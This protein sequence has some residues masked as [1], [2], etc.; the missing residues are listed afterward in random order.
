MFGIR[1]IFAMKRLPKARFSSFWSQYQPSVST[2]PEQ[3]SGRG[4]AFGQREQERGEALPALRHAE[5]RGLLDP[6]DRVEAGVGETDD[7]RARGLRLQDEGRKSGEFSGWRTEPTI[8][9]PLDVTNFA[10][11]ASS[12]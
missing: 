2:V 10:V 6:V 3:P 8:L 9:P 4:R 12:A 5:F 11:S 7:F 1:P